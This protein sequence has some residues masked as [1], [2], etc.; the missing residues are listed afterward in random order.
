MAPRIC[1]ALLAVCVTCAT[2]QSASLSGS[3]SASI[4]AVSSSP[5]SASISA[6]APSLPASSSIS[7]VT[8]PSA[9][10]TQNGNFPPL[11]S[12]PEDFSPSGLEKL[13]DIVSLRCYSGNH[14]SLIPL[15]S[16]DFQLGWSSAIP[17]IHHDGCT[18]SPN[19]HTIHSA[20]S[21]SLLVCTRSQGRIPEHQ[22][23][24]WLQV[25]RGYRSISGRR[26]CE[27]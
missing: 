10:S 6:S 22:A 27:K 11:G 4:S 13:W 25:R 23:S 17:S 12:I 5:Q 16:N 1:A 14:F 2:A 9:T 7:V 24:E 19:R 18:N 26:C 8:S 20:A 21:L 3:A 15:A